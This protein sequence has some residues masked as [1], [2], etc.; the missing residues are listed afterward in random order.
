MVR[1]SELRLPAK[2]KE[3]QTLIVLKLT[4]FQVSL[5]LKISSSISF[6]NVC[7]IQC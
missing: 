2:K 6:C 5:R 3:K 4:L 1:S 7:E